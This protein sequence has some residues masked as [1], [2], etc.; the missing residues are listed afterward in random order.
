MKQTTWL[1]T[2]IRRRSVLALAVSGLA[3]C[4]GGAAGGG[5][6]AGLPGTGGTG[7]FAQGTIIGFGSV[8]VNGIRFDDTA[9]SVQIDGLSA[10]AQDLRL[11]MVADVQGLRGADLTLGVANAIEVWSIAQ[12]LV[13]QVQSGQ[14]K[15]AGM[16][17]QADAATVFDGI[18]SV[19]AL[20]NGLRVA[21]WGLESGTDGSRW[22]A[23][24]VALVTAT[25]MVCTGIVTATGTLN[26]FA[27]S[28][29]SVSSLRAGQLVRV[30][31]VLSSS[32]TSLQVDSFKLLGLQGSSLPQGEVEIEGL[33]TALLSGSRF[34]L[35]S[36]EVDASGASLATSYKAL[37]IGQRIEVEGIWQGG[38]LKAGSLGVESEEK[39]D[40]A[41]IEAKIEQ[42]TSLANF[43]VRGQRCNASSATISKGTVSDLKVGVKVKLHGTKAGDV[44][45]VTTL[46]FSS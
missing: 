9:A 10:S 6:L 39:L 5:F 1:N 46:E 41:E 4:G 43:V 33:V 45:M 21:V 16:L 44:L 13:S 40:E 37:A 3:G 12:G 28:G 23:T 32:G 20:A 24:R 26:G 2:A 35:G 42:F 30:Q 36:V 11:G 7:L 18:S 27:L 8:I 29:Q 19:S 14:F 22:T 34:M 25:P 31:G 15:V 38:V 17:V